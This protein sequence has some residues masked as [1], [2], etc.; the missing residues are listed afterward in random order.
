MGQPVS[1]RWFILLI[2]LVGL[3]CAVVG[4]VLGA[5][6]ASGREHLTVS[7]LMIGESVAASPWSSVRRPAHHAH[8]PLAGLSPIRE[9]A[10][11]IRL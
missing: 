4:T 1:I 11:L 3:C 10:A 7:L 9:A 2:L 6:K 5:M 8:R